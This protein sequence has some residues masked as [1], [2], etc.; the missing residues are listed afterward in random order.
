MQR[1]DCWIAPTH[2]NVAYKDPFEDRRLGPTSR[3]GSLR[4]QEGKAC[5]Q[6][7]VM[8]SIKLKGAMTQI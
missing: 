5:C 3:G 7:E 2:A 8:K 1:C 6:E 4:Q